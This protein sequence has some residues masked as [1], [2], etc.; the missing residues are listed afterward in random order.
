MNPN[1]KINILVVQ[2]GA[3]SDQLRQM[4]EH[5][6]YFTLEA[7]TGEQ[8]LSL[9]SQYVIDLAIVESALPGM[10]GYAVCRHL[11]QNP[12]TH[13]VPILMLSFK[14]E[15]ADKVAGFE[16][17]IDDFLTKPFQSP[18]LVHRVRVLLARQG[19]RARPDTFGPKRGK[20]IALF[21][22]KGGVGRTTIGVNLAVALRRRT[23][24]K[25]IL[26]DA[27]FFFGDTALHLDIP[28]A[29]TIV[30]LI[31]RIDQLDAEVLEQVLVPHASGVRVLLSPRNPEDVDS[32][33][34]S[35]LARLIDLMTTCYDYIVVDCQAI[36]DER[37]LVLLEKADAI[38]LVIKPE[39]GCVKNMAVFSELAAKLG[40]PFD[41]KVHIVLNRAGSKSGIGPKEI[42]RIFR[43]QIAFQ[44][45]SGGNAVVVS[46][47]RGVP[48]MIEHPNHPFS[49]QVLQVADYLVKTLP[50]PIQS[51]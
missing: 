1:E 38:L 47:N 33:S 45:A 29:H 37:T 25:I 17:G 35:H 22:T 11:R 28:P 49:L 20:T 23:Q 24:G 31:E 21:G 34:P 12:A 18:E 36:Y 39:V 42:E 41:K 16:A 46:V 10:D 27:D 26:F 3:T 8:A 40:L 50:V 9:I 48:L 13:A 30:D 43:R 6:D 7:L 14:S 32:I 4:L 2:D 44:I 15:I 5:E 19:K 51:G